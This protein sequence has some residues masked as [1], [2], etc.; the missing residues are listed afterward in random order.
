MVRLLK[1]MFLD[2]QGGHARGVS[3]RCVP[4]PE[5]Q[6]ERGVEDAAGTAV[7][8]PTVCNAGRPLMAG[9]L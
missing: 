2:V 6:A 7:Q 8:R 5:F 1:R 9:W 3:S 4:R